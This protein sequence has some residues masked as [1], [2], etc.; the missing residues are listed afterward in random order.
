M[1]M[2]PYE[3]ASTLIYDKKYGV[4]TPST[5]SG[6]HGS[7]LSYSKRIAWKDDEGQWFVVTPDSSQ[8]TNR[9]IK[10]VRETLKGGGFKPVIVDY[11]T[12]EPV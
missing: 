2:I 11:D 10:A 8:T 5:M 3:R 4:R 1:S 7:I 9:H 12:L 6:G